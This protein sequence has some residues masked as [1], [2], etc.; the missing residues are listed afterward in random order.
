M[1]E[2]DTRDFER[3][4]KEFIAELRAL[5]EKHKI[6][7]E[8]EDGQGAFLYFDAEPPA[9]LSELYAY[10]YEAQ[11]PDLDSVHYRVAGGRVQQRKVY[12]KAEK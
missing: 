2:P 12:G 4:V 1:T 9:G 10:E 11:Y 3:R 5:Q 8:H 7:L 6:N